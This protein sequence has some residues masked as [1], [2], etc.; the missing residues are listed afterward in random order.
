MGGSLPGYKVF[1]NLSEGVTIIML[2]Q[3]FQDFW[4]RKDYVSY[5]RKLGVIIGDGCKILSNPRKCFGSE[6]WLVR[7][8]NHVEITGGVIIL[9][10]DGSTWVTRDKNPCDAVWGTVEIGDNV[11]VGERAI[12]MPNIK[13]GNNCVIGAGSIVTKSVPDNSVVA[14]C[15]A[16]VISDYASFSNRIHAK[17]IPIIGM[18]RE[19]QIEYS[20]KHFGIS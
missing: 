16:R 13:V 14:G 7:I 20:K 12:I 5:A 19:K 17:A 10:H 15:P 4:Y 6:P 1:W 11:F 18:E 2:F 8:G 9:T 3:L